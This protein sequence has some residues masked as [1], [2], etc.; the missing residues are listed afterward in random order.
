M[1]VTD[2]DDT[3]RALEAWAKPAQTL[4]KKFRISRLYDPTYARRMNKAECEN[5]IRNAKTDLEVAK[6]R[7]EERAI[8]E[9]INTDVIVR[10][11]AQMLSPHARPEDVDE[12]W[13]HKVADKAKVVSDADMQSL[14][15]KILAGE[16]ENPS[17]FSYRVLEEVSQLSKVE[18]AAFTRLAGYVWMIGPQFSTP[19]IISDEEH[20]TLWRTF[21]C[22]LLN[23]NLVKR[24]KPAR[25]IYFNDDSDI[26]RSFDVSYFGRNCTLRVKRTG[27]S[28]N[29]G[30]DLTHIGQALVPLCGGEPIPGE[31]ERVV[32]RWR[33]EDEFDVV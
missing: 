24:I 16:A 23:T 32:D 5:R 19:V 2:G 25:T 10:D 17:S 27:V 11:A 1:T 26:G 9:Q 31:Y 33:R 20:H 4:I 28:F 21:D 29:F 13:I 14:W 8:N 7:A 12:D 6:I 18:A 15:A 22:P 3:A 30:I